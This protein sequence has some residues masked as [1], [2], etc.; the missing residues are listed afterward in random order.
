VDSRRK[1]LVPQPPP[2][3]FGARRQRAR[4][5]RS[6]SLEQLRSRAPDRCFGAMSGS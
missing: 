3:G 4:R 2:A 6:A 5:A 1:S